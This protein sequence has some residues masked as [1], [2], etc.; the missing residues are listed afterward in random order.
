MIFN[1]CG[2]LH[3]DIFKFGDM[4]IQ[5]VR[6]YKYLGIKF[7]LSGSFNLAKK[8]LLHKAMRAT[9]KL[10]TLLSGENVMPKEALNLY[11][12]L[13]L[14]IGLYGAEIWGCIDNTKNLYKTFE[15]LPFEK[16]LISFGKHLLGVRKQSCN[17]A[18]RGELGLFPIYI[19]IIIQMIKY[20]NRIEQLDSNHLLYQTLQASKTLSENNKNSWYASLNKI[21]IQF[22][23]S[24]LDQLHWKNKTNLREILNDFYFRHWEQ[25]KTSDN[26][27][28]HLY[29]EIKMNL[30]CE[31]Y[32]NQLKNKKHRHALTK[33]RIS[34]H[35]LR[36]ETGRYGINRIPRDERFCTYCETNGSNALEN[37]EHF[38][39]DCTAYTEL[40][41]TMLNVINSECP[42]FSHMS[43]RNKIIYMLTSEHKIAR[44]VGKFCYEANE[45]RATL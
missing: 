9:F 33:L 10:K 43:S 42:N 23:N 7:A 17:T 19:D 15:T 1:K 25:F 11:R 44:A 26:G 24:S 36:I 21:C 28:L 4:N 20:Y 18:I 45:I 14:P 27:K 6:E 40:R 5:S 3:R 22:S 12:K 13:I 37:E 16:N 2:R 31:E 34:A 35:S 32:L 41:N 29:G 8:D 30:H 39:L 38:L